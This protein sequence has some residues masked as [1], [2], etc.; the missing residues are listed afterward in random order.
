VDQWM[1]AALSG[2][3]GIIAR[4]LVQFNLRAIHRLVLGAT[5]T[6]ACRSLVNCLLHQSSWHA[7]ESERF[8]APSVLLLRL[9]LR[10]DR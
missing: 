9:V 8:K 2:E 4:A 3:D 1:V 6:T 7:N 10:K 5:C